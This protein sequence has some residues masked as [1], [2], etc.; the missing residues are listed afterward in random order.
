MTKLS[1]SLVGEDGFGGEIAAL[2]A[3]AHRPRDLYAEYSLGLFESRAKAVRRHRGPGPHG[4]VLGPWY[5]AEDWGDDGTLLATG[6]AAAMA[7]DPFTT[8]R[9]DGYLVDGA[10]CQRM[11]VPPLRYE[12][13]EYPDDE[14]LVEAAEA[15][16]PVTNAAVESAPIVNN[17]APIINNSAVPDDDV[18][19]ARDYQRERREAAK[20]GITPAE[21][22]A[23][24]GLPPRRVRRSRSELVAAAEDC[25]QQAIA[26]S[27]NVMRLVS[28]GLADLRP[29]LGK[30]A[31]VID[32]AE[33]VAR[34]SA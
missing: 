27:P 19:Y 32:L 28:K 21:W 2:V 8:A 5:R 1:N 18:N 11:P 29:S 20:L 23:Q 4:G 31:M 34:R 16:K 26:A 25:Q 9:L 22:R 6:R 7:L 24:K 3:R 14:P 33:A 12:G 17:I 30:P 10:T 13:V 15:P